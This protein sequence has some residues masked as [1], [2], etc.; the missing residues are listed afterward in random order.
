MAS[1]NQAV[2]LEEL[3]EETRRLEREVAHLQ[4]RLAQQSVTPALKEAVGTPWDVP[5]YSWAIAG[6]RE[7]N[8]KWCDTRDGARDLLEARR[9][10]LYNRRAMAAHCQPGGAVRGTLELL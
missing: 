8:R 2:N 1:T 7:A 4:Q 9:L 5:P 3:W 10:A 6:W